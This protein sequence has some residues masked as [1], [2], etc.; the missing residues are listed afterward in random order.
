MCVPTI[1]DAL[2]VNLPVI[3]DARALD[4]FCHLMCHG[5]ISPPKGVH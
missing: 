4:A 5:E 2:C 1:C 3:N